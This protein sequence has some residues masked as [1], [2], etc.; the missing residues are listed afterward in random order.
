[1]SSY[2]AERRQEEKDRR[3]GEIV[4]AAED[5]YRELGWDAVT[6]DSVARRAR[7]SRALVYVYFKD[8]RD[9][10]FAIATRAME[11][12]RIRFEE[13]AARSRLGLEKV[14]ALGRAYMAYGQEF[15]HYFDACARLELH[16]PEGGDDRPQESVSLEASD[17]VHEIVEESLA[18]GQRD[19]TV[20]ADLGDLAVTSRVLWGFTHGLIQIALTKGGPLAEVGISVPQLTQHAIGMIRKMLAGPKG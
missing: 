14:E 4:D 3:R 13:A 18:I 6:M 1:M 20:N 2:I 8:K 19:G 11:T 9:L 10:H 12:L 17:R 16:V 15:P 5:L 7:L